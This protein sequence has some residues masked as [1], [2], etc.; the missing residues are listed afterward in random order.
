M[1]SRVFLSSQVQ[2]G[3]RL[4]VIE[5]RFPKGSAGREGSARL[6]LDRPSTPSLEA[7]HDSRNLGRLVRVRLPGGASLFRF[8]E[9]KSRPPFELIAGWLLTCAKFLALP[10]GKRGKSGKRLAFRTPLPAE[11]S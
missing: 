1:G 4:A 8:F 11:T 6:G 7:S 9:G 10:R 2:N 3:F 5:R